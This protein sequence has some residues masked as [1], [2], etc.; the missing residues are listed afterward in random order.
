[1]G[2]E[3]VRSSVPEF[4]RNHIKDGIIKILTKDE[5]HIQ[6]FIVDIK[7]EFMDQSPEDISFPRGTNNIEKWIDENGLPKSGCPMHVRGCIV[8]NK[9]LDDN[10]FTDEKIQSGDKIKFC[11]LRQPNIFKS[12]V[13]AYPPAMNPNVYEEL[14]DSIDY[15]AQWF[16]TF[17]KPVDAIMGV[18]GWSGERINRIDDI[19]GGEY[20]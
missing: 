5:S 10:E 4:C 6:D 16:G 7:S 3:C 13:V 18:V 19:C 11:H 8:Y 9:Y 2:L 12:H 17:F 1:M 20:Y 15:E 14:K